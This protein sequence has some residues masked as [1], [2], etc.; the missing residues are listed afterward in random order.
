MNTKLRSILSCGVGVIIL[1]F[2]FSLSTAHASQLQVEAEG[3]AGIEY[4]RQQAKQDAIEDAQRNAVEKALGV[5]LTSET[6]VQNYVLLQDKILTRVEGY[7]RDFQVLG[8]T[9]DNTACTVHIR[10]TVEEMALADDVAA[11]TR[12]LPRLNYPTVAISLQEQSLSSSA[13]PMPL[14]L[15]AARQTIESDLR[16]KGFDLVNSTGPDSTDAQL[17]IRGQA[18]VQDNGASPYNERFHAYAATIVAD[19]CENTTGKVLASASSETVLPHHN[20]AIGSQNALQQAAQQLSG[21]LSDEIVSTWLEACYNEHQIRLIV[22][23]CTFADLANLERELSAIPGVIRAQ[24]KQFTSKGGE[25][26]LGWHNCNTLRL[27]EKI[28]QT[29]IGAKTLVI[30]AAG[31]YALQADLK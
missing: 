25:F 30:T 3:S 24:Q 20:F 11:L 27:A 10:A 17:L 9:C 31:T 6:V 19:I 4:S 21:K 28:D 7:V 15:I 12:I 18:Y 14:N 13:N 1:A 5:M 8:E 29:S 22:T 2:V 23:G 26:V 16:K